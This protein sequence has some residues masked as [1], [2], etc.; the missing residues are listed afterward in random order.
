MKSCRALIFTTV[1]ALSSCDS[2]NEVMEE[3]PDFNDTIISSVPEQEDE[4]VIFKDSNLEVA[5]RK[6]LKKPAGDITR[7]HLSLLEKFHTID[8][9]K[10]E[11]I[12]DLPGLEHAINLITLHL[13]YN[14]IADITPTAE[15][16][17][18]TSLHLGGNQITDLNPLSGLTTLKLLDLGGNKIT[19]ITPLMKLT[20]LT[21]LDLHDNQIPEEQKAMLRQALPNCEIKF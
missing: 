17:K 10:E 9:K 16:T 13:G 18:L 5:V 14:Y 19:D 2:E 8:Q 21:K 15:L 1:L 11:I 12:I 4:L 3:K 6:A 20:N 7:K